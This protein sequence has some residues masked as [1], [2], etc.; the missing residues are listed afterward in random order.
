MNEGSLLAPPTSQPQGPTAPPVPT[1][2]Q[3]LYPNG[4]AERSPHESDQPGPSSPGWRRRLL[5]W[6]LRWTRRIAT[7]LL[8]IAVAGLSQRLGIGS[9]ATVVVAVS[10]GTMVF[11]AA[12]RG[13]S[14]GRQAGFLVVAVALLGLLSAA[15]WSY[16]TYLNAAGAASIS[17]RT[18]DWMRDH[19]MNPIV[20][21][22]E[23]YLYA[24]T[25]PHNGPVSPDQIPASDLL[26][27]S[28]QKAATGAPAPVA[29]GELL[30]H[31]PRGEGAWTPSGRLV[32]GRPVAYTAFVRPDASHTNVVAA[33]VWLDPKATRVTYVPGTKQKGT[34]AWNSGIPA[35]ERPGLV[36]AFN[37][38]FKFKD[39]PGGYQTE[40]R[41]PV[42]LADG[43]ASL[44]LHAHGPAEIGAWGSQVHLTPDVTTVRQN[45]KLI[46]DHGR[47]E[48]GLATG[49]TTTAWGSR[50]WQLQYTNRSG[51]GITADHALVYVS[52]SN[53][54]TETLA[55]ALSKL[56]AVRAMELDIHASNPT[57]NFF[58]PAPS[59]NPVTG[60]R[61]TASM[62]SSANRFLAPDQ[63]D[64]FAV[65]STDGSH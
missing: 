48:A 25:A 56:G 31:S 62:K 38:G 53:L 61:L 11:L 33:A 14:R 58:D 39:I 64:F 54:T 37:G 26:H 59:G 1:S 41:T 63:R 55:K 35:A 24:G 32:H 10:A 21:R 3:M 47:P 45:L 17:A 19:H 23:Q 52:G 12:R 7:I 60:S 9:V 51:L 44:V 43:Q 16:T 65:T 15:T 22:L 8:V 34:W 36:A 13:R 27:T 18:G 2:S 4:E 28:G 20:D 57:F 6:V 29:S 50:R 40:G 46:V 42:P 30:R 5:R 49:S